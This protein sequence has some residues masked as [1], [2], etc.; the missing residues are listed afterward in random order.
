MKILRSIQLTLDS[1]DFQ[2]INNEDSNFLEKAIITNPIRPIIHDSKFQKLV[3]MKQRFYNQRM[4]SNNILKIVQKSKKKKS[5]KLVYKYEPYTWSEF[6]KKTNTMMDKKRAKKKEKA[7][8]N[9]ARMIGDVE[10]KSTMAKHIYAVQQA[11]IVIYGKHIDDAQF[12]KWD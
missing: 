9:F 11:Q 6:I 5:S 3:D 12:T 7:M 2:I 10:E 4:L 1:S 8:T